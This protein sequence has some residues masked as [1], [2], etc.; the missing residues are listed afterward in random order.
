V[1]RQQM[2]E[3]ASEIHQSMNIY[4]QYEM[5]EKEFDSGFIDGLIKLKVADFKPVPIESVLNSLS[6]Y[7]IKDLQPNI[8]RKNLYKV[9]KVKTVGDKKHIIINSEYLKN[10]S[11]KDRDE[12]DTSVKAGYAGLSASASFKY[13][14]EK[15]RSWASSGKNL[16][17]Q[18]N[19]L[20]SHSQDNLEWELEGEKIV[21]KR[22]KV[23]RLVKTSF[24]EKLNFENI[25]RIVDVIFDKK[26]TL[27]YKNGIY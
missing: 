24:N 7:S 11:E 2:A 5:S 22:L 23:S 21:P 16:D 17:D 4:E 10:N 15:E 27:E 14:K 13:V 6:K 18:L 9:L 19:E 1:T 26:F 3:I 12:I 20:N 25:K 8:I